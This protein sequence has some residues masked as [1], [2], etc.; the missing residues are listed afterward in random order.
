MADWKPWYLAVRGGRTGANL[1]YRA[2]DAITDLVFVGYLKSLVD[3]SFEK[4]SHLSLVTTLALKAAEKKLMLDEEESSEGE[5]P[6]D[7]QFL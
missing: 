3:R 7:L 1:S 4:T 6:P 2:V 5:P